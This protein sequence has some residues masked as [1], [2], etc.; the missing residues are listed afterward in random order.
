MTPFLQKKEAPLAGKPGT[1]L[2]APA[3]SREPHREHA[4]RPHA[5]PAKDPTGRETH[6]CPR[7][8]GEAGPPG[9]IC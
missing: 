1:N 2:K 4:P 5:A 6:T 7:L 3:K 8:N 9:R